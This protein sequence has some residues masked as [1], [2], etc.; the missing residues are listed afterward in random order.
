M[1][2]I[3]DLLDTV[4]KITGS[5]YKTAKLLGI[6]TAH[7]GNWRG[8]RGMPSNKHVIEMCKFAGIDIG[9]AIIAV[10][11]SR[12]NE[13]PLKE[14]G[15]ADLEMMLGISSFGGLTLLVVSHLPYGALGASIL[16]SA[17]LYIMLNGE[18]VKI[19][20]EIEYK[21]LGFNAHKFLNLPA[22]NDIEIGQI[23]TNSNNQ[24]LIY[25]TFR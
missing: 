3:D 2:N 25:A 12:E 1:K 9:E 13:R 20:P 23:S 7:V 11:Y 6:A 16:S 18:L 4:K 17:S 8:R 5:D 21:L 24:N 15:F 10:E 22:A 19:T 14:A